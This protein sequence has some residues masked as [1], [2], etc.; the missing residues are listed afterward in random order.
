M[1][2]SSPAP[3][4]KPLEAAEENSMSGGFPGGPVIKNLPTNARDT[5]WK[6]RGLGRSR[7]PQG[8]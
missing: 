5:S 4:L 6:I 1:T 2:L 8:N 3:A 7:M